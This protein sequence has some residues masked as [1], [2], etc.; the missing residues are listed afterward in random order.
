MAASFAAV[1]TIFAWLPL[2]DIIEPPHQQF[3]AMLARQIALHIT[4][5]TFHVPKRRVV[6]L[7]QRSREAVNRALRTIDER[8]DSPEFASIYRLIQ[9]R[10]REFFGQKMTDARNAA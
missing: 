2:R 4:I 5:R 3:D 10:A 7:Q 9:T 6:E 1:K 8:L